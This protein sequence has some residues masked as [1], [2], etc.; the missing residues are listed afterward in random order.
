MMNDRMHAVSTIT[1]CY[2]G[3]LLLVCKFATCYFHILDYGKVLQST[4]TY[5]TNQTFQKLCLFLFRRLP[6]AIGI[7]VIIYLGKF[8][9][10]ETF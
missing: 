9:A 8:I 3:R 2:G 5:Y 7:V 6:Y 4:V 10:I 1:L